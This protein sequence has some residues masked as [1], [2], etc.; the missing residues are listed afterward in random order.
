MLRRFELTFKLDDGSTKKY[1]IRTFSFSI[2]I[3]K[4][5]FDW[6][7]SESMLQS[8]SVIN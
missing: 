8:I 3:E 2:A 5:C 7:L 6:S 1:L 4:V